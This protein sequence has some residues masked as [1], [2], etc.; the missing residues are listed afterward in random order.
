M[1]A[2]ECARGWGIAWVF[3]IAYHPQGARLIERMNGLL[4]EQLRKLSAIESLAGWSRNLRQATAALNDHPLYS[5]TPYARFKGEVIEWPHVLRV[6]RLHPQAHL[7]IQA[8]PG[9]AGLD[10]RVPQE[11]F[12]L[13]PN[14]QN[15]VSTGL[16]IG[17]P[18]GYYGRIAPCSN[19]AL[20]GIDVAAGVID[21]DYTGEVKVLL[22]HNGPQAVTLPQGERIAQLICERIG[23]PD[24][25][26]VGA[27]APT[28][29]A[30]GFGSTGHAV[31]VHDP[32]KHNPLKGEILADGPRDTHLILLKGEDAPIYVPSKHLSSRQ[33]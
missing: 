16:A 26:E 32:T 4:K 13:Q 5:S 12:T 15:L 3:H 23:L 17:L 22:V 21:A 33:P 18:Q 6:Q 19:L 14:S 28:T 25:Q 2:R 9:S 7:P 29:R 8:T 20:K 27:L 30:G 11:G 1:E 24:V 10:L 31:W